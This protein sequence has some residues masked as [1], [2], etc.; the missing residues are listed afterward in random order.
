MGRL[1]AD[2]VHDDANVGMR[3]PEL[4]GLPPRHGFVLQYQRDGHAD[5]KRAVGQQAQERE[6]RTTPRAQAHEV[7]LA[8]CAARF[9][10]DTTGAFRVFY[11]AKL[12][13]GLYV[14]HAFHEKDETNRERFFDSGRTAE[15][16]IMAIKI[17]HGS[18]NVF[19]DLGVPPD[20][21][22]NLQLRSDL[23]IKLRKRLAT[24]GTTQ[25]EWAAVLGVSQPRVSDLLRAQIDRLSVDTLIT[26]RG[27][28]GAEVRLTVRN[29]TEAA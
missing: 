7:D 25:A 27:R 4:P 19:T 14:L 28:T 17:T 9:R 26:L 10:N 11:V 18:G 23:I 12:A 8:H 29:R 3:Q 22:A 21:A 15:Y 20:E 6:R 16:L 5:L 1:R 13:E 2:K 24:L